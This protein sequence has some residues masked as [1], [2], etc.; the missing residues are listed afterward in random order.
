MTTISRLYVRV[1]FGYTCHVGSGISSFASPSTKSITF[2]L[3]V[4]FAS[5]GIADTVLPKP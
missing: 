2:H 3:K 5:K 1:G 4:E